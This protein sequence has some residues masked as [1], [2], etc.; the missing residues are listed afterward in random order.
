MDP[1][2]QI[3]T[4]IDCKFFNRVRKWRNERHR[5]RIGDDSDEESEKDDE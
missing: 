5:L 3:E 2:L 1:A 4:E